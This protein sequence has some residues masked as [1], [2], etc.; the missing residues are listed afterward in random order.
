[1]RSQVKE[2]Q[3]TLQNTRQR[4]EQVLNERQQPLD[5]RR[6]T[7]MSSPMP[8]RKSLHL[9]ASEDIQHLKSEVQHLQHR[10]LDQQQSFE[11]ERQ[12]LDAANET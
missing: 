1:M 12:V 10:L 3:E 5:N 9:H 2:T 8:G 11:A 7:A 6:I 4:L